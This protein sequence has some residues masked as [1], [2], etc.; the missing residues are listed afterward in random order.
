VGGAAGGPLLPSAA[1]AGFATPTVSIAVLIVLPWPFVTLVKATA[2]P[3][4]PGCKCC[5]VGLIVSVMVKNKAP[6]PPNLK[7]T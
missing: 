4:R 5:A 6:L 3:Y 1:G 2:G 7:K